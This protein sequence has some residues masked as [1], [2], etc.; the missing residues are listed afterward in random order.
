MGKECVTDILI[1]CAF[2]E[3]FSLSLNVENKN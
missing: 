3:W 1:D 2:V